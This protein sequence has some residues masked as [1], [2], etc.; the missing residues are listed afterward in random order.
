MIHRILLCL[1][2]LSVLTSGRAQ[3]N[4]TLVVM[5][6]NLLNYRNTTT[7]C[8][9]ST[10]K[11]ADKDKYLSI[12]AEHATPDVLTVNEMGAN[13]LNPN[14]ILQNALNTNG[15]SHFEQA[16]FSNNGFS[17]LTNMLFFNKEKLKIHSQAAVSK[18]TSGVDLVR[19][20]DLYTLYYN[21]TYG[22][23][24]G[25]T[26]WITFVVAHLK[27]GSTAADK[28]D[29]ALMTSALMKY[30][31]S[32]KSKGSY[33]ICGDFN[34]QSSTEQCYKDLV[35][36]P[37]LNIRFMD[38]V[39]APGSWNNNSNFANLHTQSTH[40]S[41]TRGGCFSGG[42]MDDRFDF[43]LCGDEVM[44]GSRNVRYIS[45]SYKAL[46]QDSRRFNGDMLSPINSM[47]PV[48]VSNA[49]YDMSDHLPVILELEISKKSTSVQPKPWLS[50]L[51]IKY[52]SESRVAFELNEGVM[53][54][55]KVLDGSGKEVYVMPNSVNQ[56][57]H[58]FSYEHLHNGIFVVI[59]ETFD[60]SVLI[61]KLMIQK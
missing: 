49:L 7:Q 57:S 50:G 35:N 6:Y 24:V 11:G 48:A 19:V 38:P 41:D 26:T 36:D 25:D 30:L 1:L 12:I 61:N 22:L 59:I 60:G 14:K 9:E 2:A 28:T 8:T 33:V 5:H 39:D 52:L 31:R 16:E 54:E 29:R 27:A 23:S 15:I 46:G 58:V 45:N 44:K 55:L 37:E 32:N 21:D 43:I 20:I 17:G 18:D 4:D 13:W 51:T 47:I 53:K 42:G 56:N 3:T 40:V 10:N 34:I